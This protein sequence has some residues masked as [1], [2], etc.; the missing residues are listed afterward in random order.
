MVF[1]QELSPHQDKSVYL[2]MGFFLTKRKNP[3]L[4][5]IG[6]EE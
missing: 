6:G 5:I 3:F 2:G 4:V 1:G